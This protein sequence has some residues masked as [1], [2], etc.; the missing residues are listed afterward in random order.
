MAD[1]GLRW[2]KV[3][4]PVTKLLGSIGVSALVQSLG[5]QE[6]DAP[7]PKV[8]WQTERSSRL[9]EMAFGLVEVGREDTEATG[10]LVK[11]AGRHR[12]EL[13]RAAATIRAD[14]RTDEDLVAFRANRL[15]VAAASGRLVEPMSAEQLESFA[16]N[17]ELADVSREIAP[18]IAD[19]T[20]SATKNKELRNDEVT[21]A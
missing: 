3:P 9:L 12:K 6:L 16:R 18:R 14:G 10:E 13:R 4:G 17:R 21:D 20:E 19:G 2:R 8:V 1:D 11:A 7:V 5:D 15:L